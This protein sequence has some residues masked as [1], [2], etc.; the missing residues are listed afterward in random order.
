VISAFTS[1]RCTSI[2]AISVAAV[3]GALYLLQSYAPRLVGVLRSAALRE[4]VPSA[5]PTATNESGP[6]PSIR[7]SKL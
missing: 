4:G 2:L 7:R 5:R 3:H 6:Q 1:E